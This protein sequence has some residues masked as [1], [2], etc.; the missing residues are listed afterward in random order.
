[1][2]IAEFMAIPMKCHN[3]SR[4]CG[5]LHFIEAELQFHL[6]SL[7]GKSEEKS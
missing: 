2:I 7:G 1:M 6:P 4:G 3:K 5:C